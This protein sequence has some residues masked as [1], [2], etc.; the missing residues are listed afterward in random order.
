MLNENLRGSGTEN[1]HDYKAENLENYFNKEC[2]PLVDGH[3]YNID[4]AYYYEND[5]WDEL[6]V[7]IEDVSDTHIVTDIIQHELI[8]N[9]EF[10]KILA[11]F[12]HNHRHINYTKVIDAIR[13]YYNTLQ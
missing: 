2:A 12:K 8:E 6:T 5:A 7:W 11:N 10:R 4:T 1:E 3:V 13:T 9:E